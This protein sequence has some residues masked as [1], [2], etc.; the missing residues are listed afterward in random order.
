MNRQTHI[1]VTLTPEAIYFHKNKD[2]PEYVYV[3]TY[4]DAK[5]V[6]EL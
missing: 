5:V 6:K 1:D 3:L 4:S 2:N